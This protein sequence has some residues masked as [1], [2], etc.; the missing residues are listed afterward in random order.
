VHDRERS[1]KLVRRER[2]EVAL[3][4]AQAATVLLL[5]RSVEEDAT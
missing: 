3:Q 2:N 4:I 1:A 5:A